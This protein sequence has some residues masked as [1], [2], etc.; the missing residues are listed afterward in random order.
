MKKFNFFLL[1]YLS[2]ALLA[3]IPI[4]VYKETL[5]I[6][7]TIIVFIMLFCCILNLIVLFYS[8]LHHKNGR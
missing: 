4:F 6:I 1:I 7:M 5:S 8:L 3:F 2:I